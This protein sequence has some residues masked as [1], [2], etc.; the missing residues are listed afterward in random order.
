MLKTRRR[1]LQALAAV[2]LLP[3]AAVAQG[4]ALA[5]T[6]A[7]DHGDAP[8]KAQTEGPYFTP[9]TPLKR[10][11]AADAPGGKRLTIGGF[12]FDTACTPMAGALVELWHAD[13]QG[14]YDNQGFRLRGHQLADGEG[15]WWFDTIVPAL[16]PGRARHYHL[17]VQRPGGALLTTQLYFPGEAAND[18]DRI[19]DPALLLELQDLSGMHFGR[20]DF[21]VA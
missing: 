2:P 14:R 4:P 1:L 5:L 17:K 11:F 10:D 8:T 13:D 7:C 15:R 16:Y 9:G 19:F 3:A 21:V 20:Y 18:R 12:V 6:P